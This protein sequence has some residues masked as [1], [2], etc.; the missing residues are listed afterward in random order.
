MDRNFRIQGTDHTSFTVS[1]LQATVAFFR[2]CLGFPAEIR[3]PTS[4]QVIEHVTG[5]TGCDITLAFVEAPGHTLELI[6]YH[7]P[8]DRK[9]LHPRP[10]DTGFAHLALK[11]E[12]LDAL[13]Q[14]AAPHGFAP[15]N[16]PLHAAS[17]RYAGKNVVYVRNEDGLTLELIGT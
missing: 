1:D 13:I 12:G 3:K 6:E 2:D 4:Q 16:P 8:A 5:V 9:S 15:V 7:A 11:V 17:G 14:A 10:C